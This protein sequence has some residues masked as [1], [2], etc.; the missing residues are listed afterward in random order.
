MFQINVCLLLLCC[1]C[2]SSSHSG[3]PSWPRGEQC[4]AT[5]QINRYLEAIRLAIS[6]S[7]IFTNQNGNE[8]TSMAM[9]FTHSDWLFSLEP[10]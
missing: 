6:A 4:P 9:V 7:T 2:F 10:H 5:C 8:G 1:P 3:N